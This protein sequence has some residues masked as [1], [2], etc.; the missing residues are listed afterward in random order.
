MVDASLYLYLTKNFRKK[1]GEVDWETILF[2]Y[3]RN[4]I[5]LISSFYHK[6]SK[7]F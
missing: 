6:Y 1:K 7:E 2:T 4:D 5:D 3:F